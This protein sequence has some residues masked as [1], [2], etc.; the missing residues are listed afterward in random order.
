MELKTHVLT[1]NMH[2]KYEI[3]TSELLY[4][5]KIRYVDLAGFRQIQASIHCCCSFQNLNLKKAQASRTA[6]DVIWN[7]F[8]A[9]S[10]AG[11]NLYAWKFVFLPRSS[12]SAKGPRSFH[13]I[14]M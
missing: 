14:A 1:I 4:L 9:R 10:E 3:Q 6:S 7:P 8:R 2:N 12:L 5:S 11:V 13:Q